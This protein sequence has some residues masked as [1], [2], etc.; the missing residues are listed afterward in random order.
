[1]RG[2]PSEMLRD[3]RIH[4]NW[5]TVARIHGVSR[6]IAKKRVTAQA[7]LENR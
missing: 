2:R 3:W 6:H 7:R 4:Q 5:T 1:M